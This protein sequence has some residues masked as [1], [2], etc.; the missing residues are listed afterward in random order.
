[1]TLTARKRIAHPARYGRKD[2]RTRIYRLVYGSPTKPD[3]AEGPAGNP[4]RRLPDSIDFQALS[5]E[6]SA[7]SHL[8]AFPPQPAAAL[9][10]RLETVARY[11]RGRA[12]TA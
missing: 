7:L 3:S 8:A 12:Q 6:V 11:A 2:A 1:M 10:R 9:E 5:E 4:T